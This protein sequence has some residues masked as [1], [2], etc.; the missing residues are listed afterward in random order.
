MEYQEKTA[1]ALTK[2]CLYPCSMCPYRLRVAPVVIGFHPHRHGSLEPA[3]VSSGLAAGIAAT[4]PVTLAKPN[5]SA[6]AGRRVRQG[7]D[8]TGGDAGQGL[9]RL[10]LC[11]GD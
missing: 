2:N 6:R 9:Y 8:P 3:V 4:R 11:R 10:R 5:L 7:A 1:A